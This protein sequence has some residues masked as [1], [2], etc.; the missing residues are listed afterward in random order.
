MFVIL[1]ISLFISIILEA[2]L[3]QLPLS[4][5]LILC[6][7]ILNRS[8]KVF[9]TAFLAGILLDIFTIRPIGSTSIYFLLFLAVFLL[10]QRKYEIMSYPFV[11]ISSFAGTYLYLLILGNGSSLLLAAI[12]SIIAVAVFALL[13]STKFSI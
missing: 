4:F 6:Y 11:L 3:I 10:Y 1:L 9:A 8:G 7:S 12:S 13:K 2:T 5:I